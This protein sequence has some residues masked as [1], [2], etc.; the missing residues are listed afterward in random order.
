MSLKYFLLIFYPYQYL[1]L[2]IKL[3]FIKFNEHV[4]VIIYLFDLLGFI[5]HENHYH[6]FYFVFFGLFYFL[7]LFFF[8]FKYFF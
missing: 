1:N 7:I 6:Y 5:F 4:F 3:I 8:N 2:I